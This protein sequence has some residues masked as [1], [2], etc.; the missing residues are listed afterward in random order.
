MP[1]K[2]R[3][4]TNY[5]LE[6][7][8]AEKFKPKTIDGCN[9]CPPSKSCEGAEITYEVSGCLEGGGSINLRQTQ[10]EIIPFHVECPGNGR[11]RITTDESLDGG[12]EFTANQK[13]GTDLELSINSPWLDR[14]VMSRIGNGKLSIAGDHTILGGTEFEA[15]QINPAN[16]VL[17]V[18]WNAMPADPSTLRWEDGRWKGSQPRS[19]KA[20]PR[21]VDALE[22]KLDDLHQLLRQQS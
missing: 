20:A 19:A 22:K 6:D 10:D 2:N 7:N 9:T 11:L 17:R 1:S 3:Q 15:N 13:C 21:R 14:F 16:A 8:A 4:N 18:N 5:P 12:A